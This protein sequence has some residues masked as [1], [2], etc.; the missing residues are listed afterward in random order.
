MATLFSKFRTNKNAEKDGIWV[1]V[2]DEDDIEIVNDDGTK[3]QFRIARISISNRQYLARLQPIA[4]RSEKQN[5]NLDETLSDMIDV[6]VDCCITD[7]KNIKDYNDKNEL[8]EVPFSK[9]K[10][11]EILKDMPT[12]YEQ[13][14]KKASDMRNYLE[15]EREQKAKN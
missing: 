1:T 5:T 3:P 9:E 8:I 2:T 14:N 13:L 7:W 15:K 4:K 11:K 6:F 12:V 10:A